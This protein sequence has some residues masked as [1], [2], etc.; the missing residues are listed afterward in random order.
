MSDLNDHEK[1]I[2][3]TIKEFLMKIGTENNILKGNLLK[4]E[5]K[6]FLINN[7]N[8]FLLGLI[9]DQSVKAEIAWSLPYHLK[10]RIGTFDF[11]KIVHLYD[12]TKLEQVIK[13]KPALHRYP[14]RMAVYLLSAI[15][16]IL[17]KYNGNA[18]NIW[19]NKTA[20]EVVKKLEEFKGISHKKASL[21]A[22]I[23]TRDLD[24]N[25]LD[26]QNI[27]I[28]YDTHIKKIFKRVGLV[29]DSTEENVL[30]SAR[31]L[32]PDFPGELTTAFWT[33]GR[34]Y[35]YASNPAC[36]LCPLNNLCEKNMEDEDIAGVKVR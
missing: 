4:K 26:K 12:E 18:E 10:E 5:V 27:D 19:K 3:Q 25:I 28:A 8:A 2:V 1:E 11:Q 33:I 13:S 36:L 23:L 30:N 34:E 20:A 22:L 9:S 6:D 15:K 29:D 31:K 16:D 17:E 7:P 35:C 14:S 21:G 32:N 24:I